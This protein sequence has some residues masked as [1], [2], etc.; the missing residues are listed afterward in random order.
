[1]PDGVVDPTYDRTIIGNQFPDLQYSFN[2]GGSYKGFDV[3]AFFQGLEGVNRYY[4]M[5]TETNGTFTE[6]ALDY[7][8]EDNRDASVP[9][10]GNTIAN[11]EYSSFYLRDAS[12][13]RLKNLEIGYTLPTEWTKKVNIQKARFYFS[14]VNLFT[15]TNDDVEDY[16]PEKLTNDDRN[17]DYPSAKVY[18]LGVNITL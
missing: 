8:T 7:W 12:Y 4:W 1:V 17:R 13:L 14:G 16:D 9:R 10:W 5:N 18:S 6:P 2:L 3:Y 11:G 15:W